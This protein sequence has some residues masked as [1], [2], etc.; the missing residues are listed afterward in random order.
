MTNR[1]R[2]P[3]ASAQNQQAG[4]RSRLAPERE[5]K[6]PVRTGAAF[7]FKSAIAIGVILILAGAAILWG[8]PAL[9]IVSG[10][11]KSSSGG[12]SAEGYLD[13]AVEAKIP[14]RVGQAP[15]T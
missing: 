3:S 12:G 14:D 8:K 13:A 9:T 11:F 4:S 15:S 6:N 5:P 10:L 2:R 1:S 7:P